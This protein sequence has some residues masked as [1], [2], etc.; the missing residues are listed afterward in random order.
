MS[1]AKLRV[2]APETESPIVSATKAVERCTI[3]SQISDKAL[4]DSQVD[5]IEALSKYDH[6]PS[7]ASERAATKARTVRER[8]ERVHASRLADLEG[9]RKLLADAKLRGDR[10]ELDERIAHVAALP[11][12]L[13][14][15]LQAL[16]ALDKKCSE[17]TDGIA[18]LVL[19]AIEAFDRATA[20]A[21]NLECRAVV[22][23]A[24]GK[25]DLL[26]V[27]LLARVA[28]ARDRAR[29]G[30]VMENGWLEAAPDPAWNAPD[31]PAFD[32]ASR[33]IEQLEKHNG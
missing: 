10:A 11:S 18:D 33:I 16:V 6:D 13:W 17:V 9:A 19:D 31:K 8:A 20:I 14:P 23:R 29:M 3:E 1:A 7:E 12:R 25:P 4:S 5:E 32:E 30:R 26:Y 21:E 24:V 27:A 22:Q 2:V 15:A 28:I